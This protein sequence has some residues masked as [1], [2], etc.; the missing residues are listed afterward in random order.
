MLRRV[1]TN[2]GDYAWGSDGF[3]AIVTQLMNQ[4]EG[5]GPAPLAE[6]KL[7]NLPDVKIVQ[8]HVGMLPERQQDSTSCDIMLEF[9]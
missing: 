4:M 1:M 3:D 2:F 7:Q 9:N 6:D 8:D 5:T